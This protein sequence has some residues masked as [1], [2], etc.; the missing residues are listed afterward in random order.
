MWSRHALGSCLQKLSTLDTDNVDERR[1]K[2]T[3]VILS[4]ICIVASVIWGALYLALLGPTLTMFITFGFTA[5]IGVALMVFF[6]T[7]QI[8]ML[9]YPFFL[10]I[11]WNPI[12]MQWSLGGFSASGV[13]MT[14][15]ILAPVGALMFQT[16]RIALWWFAAYLGLIAIS[17]VF[18]GQVQQWAKPVSHD[19]SMLFFGMNLIGPSI[20][21]IVSMTYFVHAFQ[22][23]H[24]RSE[25]LLLNIL[26][27]PIAERLKEENEETI[28]DD[29]SE[30]TIL[31]ADIVDFTKLSGRTSPH[32]LVDM[33]NKVFSAFDHLTE[34]HGLEKIKTIGDAYMVVAGLPVVRP[35][36]A[37]A[38]ANMALDMLAEMPRL[39]EEIGE[40]LGLRIGINSGPVV[41]GVIGDRK[42]A[43]DTWGDSVNI[44]SRM[45]SQGMENRIQLTENTYAHLRDEYVCEE[46]GMI[47]VKGK[48]PMM[49]YFLVGKRVTPRSV[50]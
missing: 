1:H 14:W 8:E 46:R 27:A 30:V 29:F 3:L 34:R 26:P 43:Y 32:A 49:A 4:G 23:A 37:E 22:K 16:V 28:A 38:T 15:S 2:V 41:A 33:L 44:A 5:V 17:L 11:L 18:D 20:A 35:D 42:F 31:F 40:P 25:E 50:S 24:E 13:V 36:H 19:V 45:E 9:L 39:R 48:E 47:T 21:I 10:M 12:A 6:A 7:R